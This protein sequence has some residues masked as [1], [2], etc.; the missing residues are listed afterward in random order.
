MIRSNLKLVGIFTLAAVLGVGSATFWARSRQETRA[1]A[2]SLETDAL[3]FG[4][5]APGGQSSREVQLW[6]SGGKVLT[7]SD[8]KMSCGCSD[9]QLS[10]TS[11]AAG[12]TATLRVS[13][14]AKSVRG[15]SRETIDLY[16][17]DPDSPVTRLV[18]G[19]TTGEN[20][21]VEPSAIDFG[22]VDRHLLPQTKTVKL[23]IGS[24]SQEL[25]LRYVT[26]ETADRNLQVKLT[27][28]SEDSVKW[29]HVSLSPDAP[30]GQFASEVLLLVNG[31][32]LTIRV[33]V[34]GYVRGRLVVTPQS[35]V[36]GP[37]SAQSR[38]VAKTLAVTA[39]KG[40]P[41]VQQAEVSVPLQD[42][43]KTEV[44]VEKDQCGILVFVDT[45]RLP[46]VWKQKRFKGQLT[47]HGAAGETHPETVIVPL[48]IFV[49]P[50]KGQESSQGLPLPGS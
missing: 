8:V 17:N 49:Q 12:E 50:E 43:V 33:P 28:N 9:V 11:L 14:R 6:N 4:Q 26:T 47:I 41:R 35:L 29:L 20:L 34:H 18:L 27:G 44:I 32:T 36:L 21:Y 46:K 5:L 24:A 37:V 19:F 13:V 39:R 1:P 40:E 23:F 42:F 31:Q 38:N 7:I 45:S 10:R 30:S 15:P 2:L 16:T 48:I 22:I 3:D 25:D